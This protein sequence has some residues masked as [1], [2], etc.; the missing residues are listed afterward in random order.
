MYEVIWKRAVMEPITIDGSYNIRFVR[1]GEPV[2]L[3]KQS[4]TVSE[5]YSGDCYSDELMSTEP[6]GE[7]WV[8]DE[9][10]ELNCMDV[11]DDGWDR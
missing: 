10:R 2:V 1:R 9:V 7:G 8:V 11:S 5:A 3:E 4:H 6:E